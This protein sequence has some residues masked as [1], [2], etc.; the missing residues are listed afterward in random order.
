M[1]YQIKNENELDKINEFIKNND[2]WSVTN[3]CSSFSSKLWNN[4]VNDQLKISAGVINTPANICQS[5]K[6]KTGYKTNEIID[7][8]SSEY[9]TGFFDSDTGLFYFAE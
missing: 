7:S 5:I 4:I 8:I 1:S 9:K 2:T 3:N 6:D